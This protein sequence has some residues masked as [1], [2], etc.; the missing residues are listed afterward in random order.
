LPRSANRVSRTAS[1][2]FGLWSI[3]PLSDSACSAPMTTLR[4]AVRLPPGPSP[5]R[6]ARRHRP[7]PSPPL[8]ERFMDRR[9]VHIRLYDTKRNPRSCEQ[10]PP[11]LRL[12]CEHHVS[13]VQTLDETCS[14]LHHHGFSHVHLFDAKFVAAPRASTAATRLLPSAVGQ[15]SDSGKDSC[16]SA[17]GR[18]NHLSITALASFWPGF[19]R[20]ERD[21][22]SS[23]G[24]SLWS[25]SRPTRGSPAGAERIRRQ[26][27]TPIPARHLYVC[28]E[29]EQSAPSASPSGPPR[30]WTRRV[31]KVVAGCAWADHSTVKVPP[32][33]GTARYAALP[34]RGARACRDSVPMLA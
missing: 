32:P 33:R 19:H 2:S 3:V 30:P 12:R 13:L 4:G 31:R 34:L 11:A 8:E 18:C 23:T 6:A 16:W 26:R 15:Q 21:R 9:L 24:E 27:V 25:C 5:A 17:I 1:G 28:V 14:I 7:D 29:S 20:Q 22:S 10:L